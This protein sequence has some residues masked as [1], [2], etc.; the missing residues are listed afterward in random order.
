M[1]FHPQIQNAA[2]QSTTAPLRWMC[3]IYFDLCE[4]E[5]Y[6]DGINDWI[7]G[8]VK[9]IFRVNQLIQ[10]VPWLLAVPEIFLIYTWEQII[11]CSLQPFTAIILLVV[12]WTMIRRCT[13]QKQY[14]SSVPPTTTSKMRV[15]ARIYMTVFSNVQQYEKQIFHMFQ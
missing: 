7:A 3:K 2:A 9:Y 4:H 5:T 14:K 15:P 13:I 12:C 6:T 11:F 1:V 8:V 10:W